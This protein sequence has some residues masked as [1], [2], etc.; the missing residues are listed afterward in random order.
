MTAIAVDGGDL[1]RNTRT[2]KVCS[3]IVF[4]DKMSKCMYA[5]D[6]SAQTYKRSVNIAVSACQVQKKVTYV[7][8]TPTSPICRNIPVAH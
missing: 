2:Q 3:A 8:A 7:K 5:Y 1:Q 4:S 6:S